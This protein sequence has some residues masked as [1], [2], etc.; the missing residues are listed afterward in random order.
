MNA[1][2]IYLK[3]FS[4]TFFHFPAMSARSSASS[5]VVVKLLK[6]AMEESPVDLKSYCQPST[7]RILSEATK[8][9]E[10]VNE[11]VLLTFGWVVQA[12]Y[13]PVQLTYL[14]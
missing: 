6:A 9:C 13:L 8:N 2:I 1:R 10:E 12:T 7:L 5:E 11:S 14:M 4:G 3:G